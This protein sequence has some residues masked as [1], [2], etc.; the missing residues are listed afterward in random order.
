MEICAEG[1]SLGAECVAKFELASMME[2]VTYGI[3]QGLRQWRIALIVYVFQLL[4]AMT[5]GM[6]LFQVLEGSIGSSLELDKLLKGYDHTVFQDL[7][8][9]HGDSI[10]PILGQV[11]WVALAYLIFSIFINAGML[12]TV[13]QRS[14]AWK[15]FWKGGAQY[16][17]KCVGLAFL[18]LAVYGILLAVVGA[19][20]FMVLLNVLDFSSEKVAFLWI[21][22]LALILI[23]SMLKIMSASVYSRYAI[24]DGQSIWRAFISGWSTFR[25]NWR[26]TWSV[27]ILL[28][29]LQFLI[30]GIYLWVESISG[31]T[32]TATILIFFLIQQSIIY[33][34]S[35][36]KLTVYNGLHSVYADHIGRT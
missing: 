25:K 26:A 30:Y 11:R 36:W 20:V 12:Y 27:L 3:G 6:Q 8:N 13:H 14:I 17:F 10:L 21:A 1:G 16:F 15:D 35:I 19:A 22:V 32:S 33:G 4:I 9:V 34:R 28:L 18:Y 5:L 23:I 24:M 31:M 7:L 29:L 2:K